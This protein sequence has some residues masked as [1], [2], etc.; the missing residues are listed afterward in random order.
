MSW[1]ADLGGSSAASHTL[2]KTPAPAA[3]AAPAVPV[4]KPLT[5]HPVTAAI[6]S[7]AA[8]HYP[9][10]SSTGVASS[11]ASAASHVQ[12]RHTSVAAST[13]AA[14][15][16]P[17]SKSVKFI[18]QVLQPPVAAQPSLLRAAAPWPAASSLRPF[19]GESGASFK[20]SSSSE[21]ADSA[22]EFWRKRLAIYRG[23]AGG[24][25]IV[26]PEPLDE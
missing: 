7:C 18:D 13:A 17:R 4:V 20:S 1:F 25:A 12:R 2:P 23:T 24:G 10:P 11:S 15:A 5:F 3:P 26:L 8:P 21:N 9:A 22:I 19:D 14:P 16:P 6:L